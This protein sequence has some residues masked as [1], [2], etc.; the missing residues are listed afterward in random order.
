MNTFT[1]WFASLSWQQVLVGL[2]VA[3]I[4]VISLAILDLWSKP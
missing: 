1:T 4:A 3:V 2:C